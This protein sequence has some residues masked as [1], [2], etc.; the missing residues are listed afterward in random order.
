VAKSSPIYLQGAVVEIKRKIV[1]GKEGERGATWP[2]SQKSLVGQPHLAST[3]LPL[4]FFTTSCSSHAHSTDQKHQ[5]ERKFPSSFS[6]VLFI[7][8]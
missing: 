1:E 3:Q 2:A 4:S 5:K 7:S 8:F 6:K